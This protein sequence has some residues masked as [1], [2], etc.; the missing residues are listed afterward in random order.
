LRVKA[1]MKPGWGKVIRREVEL[2]ARCHK[3]GEGPVGT[4]LRD[5]K[6]ILTAQGKNRSWVLAWYGR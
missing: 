3:K 1:W 5:R 2:S 4:G 6:D